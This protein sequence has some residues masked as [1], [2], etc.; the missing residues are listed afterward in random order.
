MRALCLLFALAAQAATLDGTVTNAVTGAPVKKARVQAQSAAGNYS[1]VS[2]A[3]GRWSIPALP[4]GEYSVS[5]EC[6]GHVAAVARRPPVRVPGDG[7]VGLKVWPLGVVSGKALDEDGEALANVTVFAQSYDYTRTAPVLRVIGKAETD[8]R[9]EY[10]IFDLKP[11]RYYLQAVPSDRTFAA[12]FHAGATDLSQ[13]SAVDVLAG[14]EVSGIDFRLRRAP[15]FR[16]SGRVVNTQ[17]GEAVRGATVVAEAAGSAGT[18]YS[19][20]C[21]EGG[22]FT[23]PGVRP[24]SYTVGVTASSTPRA[25]FGEQTVIVSA[26]DVE[27]VE[28]ATSPA[29]DVPGTLV[30]EGPPLTQPLNVRVTVDPAERPGFTE[31]ATP[32]PDGSFT[33]TLGPLVFALQVANIPAGLYL[34]DIRFGS[35]D[36]SAGRIDVRRGPAPLTLTLAPNPGRIAGSVQTAD[37]RQAAGVLVAITPADPANHRIDLTRTVYA[38]AEGEFAAGSLAPGEYRVFAWEQFDASLAGSLELRRLLADR[39]TTVTVRAGSEE[40]VRVKP[41]TET[42]IR[43]ARRRLP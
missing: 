12:Q 40:S 25:L 21:G 20:Q 35:E 4:D 2:D 38:D 6:Q 23:I 31:N 27:G 16:I 42:E 34:R 43:D 7:T 14:G 13:A 10:R 22:L 39:A 24:G 9:G 18:R 8:D 32:K 37:G 29:V 3:S 36:A 11:G 30:V 41:L 15:F 5:V 26:R 19:A 33:M 1:A 28:L 17:S